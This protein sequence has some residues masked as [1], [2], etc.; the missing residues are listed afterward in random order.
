MTSPLERTKEAIASRFFAGDSI[1]AL[2]DDYAESGAFVL[3]AI[4]GHRID[5]YE[6]DVIEAARAY[7]HKSH[8]L[9]SA[10]EPYLYSLEIARRSMVL[11]G[12]LRAAVE[13]LEEVSP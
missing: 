2:M 1:E 12:R 9:S 13:A 11:R 4:R 8:D 10:V 7:I 3:N 5:E 6:R